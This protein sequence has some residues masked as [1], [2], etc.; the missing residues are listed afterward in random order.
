MKSKIL[1]AAL[2][3]LLFADCATAANPISLVDET[4]TYDVM[5]KWGF[6]NKVA[7]YATMTLRNDGDLYQAAVFAENA[8]WANK[9]YMLRDTLYTTMT[10]NG[11]IRYRIHISLMRMVNIK[12]MCC[13]SGMTE[14]HSMPMRSDINGKRLEDR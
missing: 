4:L 2:G 12:R 9:I 8:P 13:I 7:G 11:F 10:K 14:I 3:L 5:Y 1:T 6:I